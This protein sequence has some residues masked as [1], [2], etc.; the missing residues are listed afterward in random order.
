MVQIAPRLQRLDALLQASSYGEEDVDPEGGD[1]LMSDKVTYTFDELVNQVQASPAEVRQALQ[2]RH[3]VELDG[4]WRTVDKA[5]MHSLLETALFLSVQQGWS[6]DA[7]PQ[8]DLLEGLQANGHDAR[9]VLH[10]LSVYG[11]QQAE[12]IWKL[13]NQKVCRVFAETLLQSKPK[14]AE[15]EFLE[16]WQNSV[17]QDMA[18]DIEMLRGMAIQHDTGSQK[19]LKL[20]DV[21]QLPADPAARFRAAFQEQPQWTLLALQ[22]YIEDLQGPGRSAEALLLKYARRV[23]QEPG[24][25]VLYSAR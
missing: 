7:L 4:A 9:L 3:A 15:A 23:Q 20:F 21:H 13:D 2:E 24:A 8:A 5:Y 10:F 12:G 11:H 6:H 16:A 19:M 25:P 17:P 22:P 18:P 14:W 1:A